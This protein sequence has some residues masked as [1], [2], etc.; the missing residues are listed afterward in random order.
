VVAV[1]GR[2]NREDKGPEE[3]M[4]LSCSRKGLKASEVGEEWCGKV[5]VQGGVGEELRE[6][7]FG[8][9]SC[10]FVFSFSICKMELLI[11]DSLYILGSI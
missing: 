9:F 6:C 10:I 3:G 4:S 1:P 7:C 2:G 8:N 5:V 11:T